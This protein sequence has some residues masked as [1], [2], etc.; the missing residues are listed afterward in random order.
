MRLED[1]LGYDDIVIQ[2]HDNPDA[3]ALASGYAVYWYLTSKGKSPRFIYRG[4]RKVTKS[5]LLIMISE[6]NIPV[7]YEPEFEDKP[8][9]LIAVDCQPGQKNISIIEAGTVAVIDHHQVNGTKPPFSDIRS[10]MG[11]CSTVVWDMIRAEGI[12]VNTD[13]FLPTA[14]Y[15]GLYTDTNKLT[16]VS[17][18]LDRDMID[19]LRADKSLVREMSNSNISLDELEITGKA[20]LGYNYLE[21]YECLI[22][23]AEE[24][25]PCILGVI[26]D[27]VLEAEKVNVC[28]AYFESPYEV[29][30]SIRSCTKEVHADELAAFLTDGIGGGGGHL[31]KAGGTIRPE[32]IDKP[33]KEVLYERLKAYYD[34]YKIIYA[35]Q[36][37]LKGGLKPYE[38]IPLQVG[39][40]R[41]KEIFP[42]GTVVEIRTMEGDINI[43]IKDDTYLMIGIEGEIYPITEEKL[44]KSYIDFGKAYEHE[45]EYIP[46]IKNTHTGEKRSVPE[47]AHAVV[48]K[49]ISKIYAKPLT[50]YIKLFTAWDK[51]KYYS[52]VPGDYIARRDDDEHDIYIISKD[53]F[54]RLYRPWKR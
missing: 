19:A 12:D 42:V 36:T 22:V 51:E 16:E 20:I 33:A 53:L 23:E 52:G 28:L 35:E 8:E 43:T 18:P 15:Y 17:H 26:A 46:T 37:T 5:N 40:V 13:D 25:D 24:C 38:K 6:L 48:A 1:L 32:K 39:T 45:F 11:S 44:R 29:K 9:L 31:F 41:L 27:F 4:S 21:E 14:L 3:D 54:S 2:C 47:Y 50:E 10:N 30:L 34:M 7:K 49:S